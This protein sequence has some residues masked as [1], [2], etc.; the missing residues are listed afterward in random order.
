MSSWTVRPARALMT[1]PWIVK[2]SVTLICET[3][4]PG[5]ALGAVGP[6]GIGTG[7]L[8]A[9]NVAGVVGPAEGPPLTVATPALR[10]VSSGVPLAGAAGLAVADRMP[11]PRVTA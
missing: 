2:L 11:E 9:L 10:L 5:G 6:A 1:S 8:A 7:T 4:M 3:R